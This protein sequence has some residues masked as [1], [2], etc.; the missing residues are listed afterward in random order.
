MGAP[1]RRLRLRTACEDRKS[2]PSELQSQSNLVCRLLLEKKKTALRLAVPGSGALKNRL[3][4][5]RPA[6]STGSCARLEPTSTGRC[7][8][9]SSVA[10][11]R[12]RQFFLPT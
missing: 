10:P 11:T 7:T 3:L 4:A 5:H 8:R 1:E 9:V 12:R 6:A 2:T